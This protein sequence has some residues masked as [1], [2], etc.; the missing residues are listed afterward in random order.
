V[1]G[2]GRFFAKMTVEVLLE[3]KM[4]K[5][6]VSGQDQVGG[7]LYAG[8]RQDDDGKQEGK[9]ITERSPAD[10]CWIWQLD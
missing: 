9:M 4:A 7:K 3:A 6:D 8:A 10:D 5:E 2:L 1:Y